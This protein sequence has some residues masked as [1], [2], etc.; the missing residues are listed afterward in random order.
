MKGEKKLTR[1]TTMFVVATAQAS[2]VRLS[3]CND[4]FL[5][6]QAMITLRNSSYDGSSDD[7]LR[8][9][10]APNRHAVAARVAALRRVLPMNQVK[11]G[12]TLANHRQGLR[13]LNG[14]SLCFQLCAMSECR[15]M[16]IY[17]TLGSLNTNCSSDLLGV[18]KTR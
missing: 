17:E 15:A 9:C 1:V 8:S 12:L 14:L 2:V 16:V 6:C 7:D 18:V 10:F 3:F 5:L 4:T 13:L 11:P